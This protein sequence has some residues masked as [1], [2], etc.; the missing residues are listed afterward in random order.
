[1]LSFLLGCF[2]GKAPTNDIGTRLEELF[3]GKFQV[4]VSN[5][6]LLD[7]MAQYRGDKQAIVGEKSDQDVQFVL[8]WRTKSP[9][10]GVDPEMV[11]K[12]HEQAKLDISEAKNLVALL[13]EH[14]LEKFSVGVIKQ[15][16]FIQVFADPVPATREQTLHIV[17]AAL[18][19]LSEPAQTSIFIE[20]ME[21][22][23]YQTKYQDLIPRGH[24]L[25]GDGWQREQKTM[26]IDFESNRW[27][28]NPES[29]RA[30]QYADQSYQQALAW[31][32]RSLPPSTYLASDKFSFEIPDDNQ[33]ALRYGFPYFAKKPEAEN[34]DPI[35][36]VCGQYD[37]DKGTFT[38]L[39]K[40]TEF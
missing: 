4:L 36:Y 9:G 3:P 32:K 21:P 14:R 18:H 35:G 28:I 11:R 7:V 15:A 25:T 38:Q 33:L 29:K 22:A 6:K 10:L 20:L 24:W 8:D 40:Q 26:S 12:A 5:L 13:K 19:P 34:A 31:A 2:R 27:Q 39:R 16:A 37:S 23:A 30:G 17:K 1:M